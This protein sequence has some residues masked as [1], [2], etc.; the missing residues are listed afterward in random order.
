MKNILLP[1]LK[2]IRS[3]ILIVLSAFPFALFLLALLILPA[4]ALMNPIGS[5]GYFLGLKFSDKLPKEEQT[6]L[7]IQQKSSFTLND[8]K[9]DIFVIE[10]FSTYCSSCF[11]NISIFNGAYAAIKTDPA[12]EGAVR[13]FSIAIGNTKTEVEDY[14]KK[15]TIFYPILTDYEFTA[16]KALGNPRVPYTLI[17]RKTARGRCIVEY[18]HQGILTSSDEI[19]KMLKGSNP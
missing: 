8:I 5:C 16:H 12:L 14:K 7:G 13:I 9:G 18:S 15:Y 4:H 3:R 11:K 1:I 19:L 10:V 6:Y 17:L 2:G